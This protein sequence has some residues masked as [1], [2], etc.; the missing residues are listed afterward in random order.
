MTTAILSI[1]TVLALLW[2]LRV[3]ARL[4]E[5]YD[6]LDRQQQAQEQVAA[7]ALQNRVKLF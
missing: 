1:V 6:R 2:M 4:R 7:E 3:E 5:L